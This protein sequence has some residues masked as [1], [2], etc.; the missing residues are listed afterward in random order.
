MGLCSKL[1]LPFPC[2]FFSFHL[3]SYK[4]PNYLSSQLKFIN[5]TFTLSNVT[6]FR[7]LAFCK[8][9]HIHTMTPNK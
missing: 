3:Y 9:L 6:N 4:P 8:R 2:P 1:Y 7:H 5:L